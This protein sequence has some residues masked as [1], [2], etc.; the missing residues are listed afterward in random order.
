V[1]VY[2][3]GR[4][5][6]VGDGEVVIPLRVESRKE[7]ALSFGVAVNQKLSALLDCHLVKPKG[8]DEGE[9]TGVTLAQFLGELGIL[10]FKSE[11]EETE[12]QGNSIQVVGSMSAIGHPRAG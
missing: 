12:V 2:I 4:R 10:G 5:L 3:V 11:V 9:D 8:G 1:K 7:D 6:K